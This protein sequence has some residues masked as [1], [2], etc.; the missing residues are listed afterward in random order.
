MVSSSEG[1][2]VACEIVKQALGNFESNHL[3]SSLG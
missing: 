2:T 3:I 1:E